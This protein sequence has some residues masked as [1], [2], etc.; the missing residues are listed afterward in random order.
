MGRNKKPIGLHLAQ[1]NPSHLTVSEI[2]ERQKSEIDV[3]F[4][5]VTAPPYLN[6]KQK[7][8][9]DDY[10]KKLVAI[11]IMTE[12]DTDCLARYVLSHDLYVTYTKDLNK[13]IKSG[14][15]SMIKSIQRMQDTAFKQ[16][17]A[18]AKDLGLTI[19]S[20][21][22]IEVPQPPEDDDDEL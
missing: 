6:E 3:P 13:A 4:V 20:R 21:C 8:I 17:Q 18:S 2:E 5:D 7:N 16:A 9:F 11:G 1:G 15:M 10:A 22:K 12:L 14:D 19:T